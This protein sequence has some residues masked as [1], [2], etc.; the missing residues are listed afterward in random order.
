M[1]K[2][3]TRNEVIDRLLEQVNNN[4][5]ILVFGAGIG[6]TA[7]C[8][9][10]G[11]ADIICVYSTAKYR[12]MGKP[13]LMAWLPYSNCNELM[14]E[15][16]K[17]ILP[18]VKNTP[19]VAGIGAH[20]PTLD[21][22]KMIDLVL[23]LGYSGV[24]NEPFVG[25]YGSEFAA[26]LEKAG[27]G[28]SREVEL[29]RRA[30]RIGIFTLAWAFNAEEAEVMAEAGADVIGAMIGVTTGGL[31]GAGETVSLE[32]AVEEIQAVCDAAKRVNPNVLVVTHGGPIKD[33][34]SAEYSVRNTDAV[35]YVAGSSGERIPTEKAVIELTKKYKEVELT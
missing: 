27:I 29:I 21:L 17:E 15:M 31:T 13:S 8:A 16:S 19:C 4:R 5:M 10:L 30:S 20:D 23:E 35:G 32:K 24:T 11:G 14:L 3:F 7:K 6:L 1:A 22:D 9:E 33:V 34:E 2:R 12:M 26:Q 18:V 28:F 25:M